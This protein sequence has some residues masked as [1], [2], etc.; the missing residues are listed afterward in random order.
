MTAKD[1]NPPLKRKFSMISLRQPFLD[2]L[3]AYKEPISLS[4]IATWINAKR[5]QPRGAINTQT[6]HLSRMRDK[7]LE[8]GEIVRDTENPKMFVRVPKK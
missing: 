3:D 5:P 7:L 4:E 8:D 1:D 6:G 2:A